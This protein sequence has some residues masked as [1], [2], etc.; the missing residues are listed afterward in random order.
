[1]P[2]DGDG[3]LLIGG[4]AEDAAAAREAA[5]EAGAAFRA[6]ASLTDG[7]RALTERPWR[8]T[9]LSLDAAGEDLELI[10]RVA[11][12][13]NAGALVLVAAAP[14]LRLAMEAPAL[15]AAELLATP[16]RAAMLEVP[17]APDG[18]ELPELLGVLVGRVA[19]SPPPC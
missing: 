5:R 10:R 18:D 16:L 7:L 6:E 11:R 2:G 13:P 15:G 12:E 17:D 8:A 3:V 19:D 14:S 4:G 1:M 9:L